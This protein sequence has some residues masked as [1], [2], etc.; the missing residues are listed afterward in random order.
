MTDP[1]FLAILAVIALVACWLLVAAGRDEM[2]EDW[3]GV[4]EA[5]WDAYF[6]ALGG[7]FGDQVYPESRTYARRQP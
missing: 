7:V 4:T 3:E 1:L 2:D 5:E 6:A